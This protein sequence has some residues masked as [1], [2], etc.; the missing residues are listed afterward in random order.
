[1]EAAVAAA[2]QIVVCKA[3]EA[4]HEY[5]HKTLKEIDGID[6]SLM[7]KCFECL[8]RLLTDRSKVVSSYDS[9]KI[10]QI[11]K[12]MK[13]LKPKVKNCLFCFYFSFVRCLQIAEASIFFNLNIGRDKTSTTKRS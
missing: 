5:F 10:D 9:N 11:H 1:M 2:G 13:K 6:K 7:D 8:S 4:L 12:E 3:V